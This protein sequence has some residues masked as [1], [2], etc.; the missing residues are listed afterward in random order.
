MNENGGTRQYNE[1]KYTFAALLIN[2]GRVFD[3]CL[4]RLTFMTIFVMDEALVH[5]RT[6]RESSNPWLGR[7]TIKAVFL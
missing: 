7:L 1:R 6:S 4:R 2:I 5:Y 3:P